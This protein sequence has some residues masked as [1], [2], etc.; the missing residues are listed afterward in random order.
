MAR[1]NQLKN[2]TRVSVWLEETEYDAYREICHEIGIP[3]NAWVRMT[4]R[5]ASGWRP[6]PAPKAFGS[7]H[8]GPA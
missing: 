5:T 8:V 2:G 7:L 1:P 3:F 6:A 4:L